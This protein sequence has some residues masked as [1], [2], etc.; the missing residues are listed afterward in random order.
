[1]AWR[2]VGSI[3]KET[4]DLKQEVIKTALDVCKCV[5]DAAASRGEVHVLCR[6]GVELVADSFDGFPCRRHGDDC[7]PPWLPTDRRGTDTTHRPLL[8]RVA[9]SDRPDRSHGGRQ[10]WKGN[11]LPQIQGARLG[12]SS[13]HSRS[14]PRGYF[15]QS[16]V[17]NIYARVKY[18]YARIYTFKTILIY[19]LSCSICIYEL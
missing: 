15:L 16:R 3:V 18:G 11:W 10:E 13:P 4:E 1:M 17:D 2:S 8:V 7:R 14:G 9:A 19:T 5:A 12:R 6:H